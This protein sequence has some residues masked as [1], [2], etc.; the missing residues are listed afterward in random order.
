[1]AKKLKSEEFLGYKIVFRRFPNGFIEAKTDGVV[2][3]AFRTKKE[4]FEYVKSDI[5]STIND[6]ASNKI[7]EIE[8]NWGYRRSSGNYYTLEEVDKMLGF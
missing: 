5:L 8:R 2:V 6:G 3:G 1:M 7:R 4:S